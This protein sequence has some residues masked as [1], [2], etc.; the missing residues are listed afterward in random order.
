MDM[1]A[2]KES[3]MTKIIPPAEAFEGIAKLSVGHFS[4]TP[5]TDAAITVARSV[6]DSA[7]GPYADVVSHARTLERE[8]AKLRELLT[9]TQTYSSGGYW[10]QELFD[11]VDAA[12]GDT[13]V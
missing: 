3:D 13:N 4:D 7:A 10:P 8:N 12:L 5:R 9:R 1:S 6:H 2:E 11:A